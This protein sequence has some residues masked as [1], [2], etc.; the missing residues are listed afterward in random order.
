MANPSNF[1]TT[2]RQATIRWL[3]AL[4]DLQALRQEY[5]ALGY[6]TVMPPEAFE[7]A[8]ADIVQADLVAAVGS[9]QAIAGFTAAGFHYTTLYTMK[10]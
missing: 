6:S 4:E 5:D 9:I 1:V 2:Y 8:N 3:E 10:T 7:G